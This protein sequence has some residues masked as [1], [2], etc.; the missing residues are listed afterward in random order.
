[1]RRLAIALGALAGVAL[2]LAVLF[3]MGE[4]VTLHT[5][6]ENGDRHDTPLWVVDGLDGPHLRTGTPDVAWLDRLIL[7]PR[8]TL[9]RDGASA[10]Y[11]AE[12]S[13]DAALRERVNTAMAEKYGRADAIIRQ[14]R[15][16]ENAVVV[17]LTPI[18]DPDDA[19]R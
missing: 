17:R 3:P 13:E 5:W 9:E 1:M 8:V 4:V 12:P 11:L 6:D 2:L 14:V 16:V 18:E 7:H 10:S 19:G 15:D